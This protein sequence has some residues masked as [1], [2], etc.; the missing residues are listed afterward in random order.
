MHRLQSSF[1]APPNIL[2]G[3]SKNIP[4]S[5]QSNQELDLFELNSDF[6]NLCGN[7]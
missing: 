2:T 5:N 7:N 6:K 4:S 3:I 1:F